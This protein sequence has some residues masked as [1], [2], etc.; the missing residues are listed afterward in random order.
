M[1]RTPRMAHQ[2]SAA[3]T[4]LALV[5]L[6]G[7]LFGAPND[8]IAKLLPDDVVTGDHFGRSVDVDAARV[9]VGSWTDNTAPAD[10]GFV[11]LFEAPSGLPLRRIEA[12]DSAHGDNFGYSVGISGAT[13][14]IGARRDADQGAYSGSAYLFDAPTGQQL[15]KLLPSDGA[16]TDQFG[17]AVA[18]D[19]NYALV[20]APYNDEMGSDAGAAYLFDVTTG[21]ELAKLLPLPGNAHMHFGLSV[22]IDGPTVLVG[23]LTSAYVFDAQTHALRDRILPPY[24]TSWV[25][26]TGVSLEGDFAVVGAWQS[27]VDGVPFVGEAFVFDLTTLQLVS[28]L[29]AT[30]GSEEAYF[31][32]VTGIHGT[33]VVVGAYRQLD[34]GS[35]APTGGAYLFDALS[36]AQ[37]AKLRPLD[38]EGGDDFGSAVAIDG[39]MVA[40]GAWSA[41]PNGPQSGAAYL[42]DASLG[43]AVPFCTGVGGTPCPCDNPGAVGHGCANEHFPEGAR[44]EPAGS[45]EVSNDDFVLQVS[46]SAPSQPGLFFQGEVELGGGDGIP[47]GDG[48]RCAGINVL[49]LQVAV[50]NAAGDAASSL[51]I[52]RTA[53]LA[54]GDVRYCQWWYRDPVPSPCG[55]GFNLSNGL[56]VTWGP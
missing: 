3:S 24:P 21:Q 55:Q 11:Y 14:L 13:V 31:G 6:P 29:R 42:F 22:A 10:R 54:P 52:S 36:G 8:A 56:A 9:A 17:T 15:F 33:T 26:G 18:I 50:A 23:S 41:S 5:G 27:T 19:G 28:E 20:G 48:L 4:L 40:V 32:G 45:P 37:I 34:E 44:L 12:A 1:Q 2:I 16:P 38:L 39:S 46:S 51:S 49:R 47:F 53:G 7:P 30:D 25:F 35:P 43:I